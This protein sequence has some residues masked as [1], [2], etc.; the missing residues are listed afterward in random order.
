MSTNKQEASTETG[1]GDRSAVFGAKAPVTHIA[2]CSNGNITAAEIIAFLPNWIR[3]TDVCDRLNFNGWVAEGIANVA[4]E[5][6]DLPRGPMNANSALKVLQAGKRYTADH[7][8]KTGLYWTPKKAYNTL[9]PATWDSNDLSLADRRLNIEYK[10]DGYARVDSIPFEDLAR[11]VVN[12]PTGY[13]AL[14]LT[15]CVEHAQAHVGEYKFPQD[16]QSLTLKLGGPA[17]VKYGHLDYT[18]A[19]RYAGKSSIF[20]G[21]LSRNS[22]AQSD[23]TLVTQTMASSGMRPTNQY[24]SSEATARSDACDP[25]FTE[26]SAIE[27]G[28]SN[29]NMFLHL[30]DNTY[31]INHHHMP[32]TPLR[33]EISTTRQLHFNKTVV[34]QVY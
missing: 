34:I 14:D 29:P 31:Q 9:R 6:L 10:P 20:R 17:P 33:T 13:D 18:A 23:D 19:A 15:R 1:P 8:P 25:G 27:A 16:F 7:S 21:R 24:S 5:H 22:I 32:S 2:L 4:N 11:H 26:E 3:N 12:M 28:E 30:T